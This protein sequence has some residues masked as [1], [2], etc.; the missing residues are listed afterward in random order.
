MKTRIF[1][2]AALICILTTATSVQ[3][4][5]QADVVLNV[6]CDEKDVKDQM[7]SFLGREL[8]SL[9]DVNIIDIPRPY[10][11]SFNV[12][13][14]TSEVGSRTVGYAISLVITERYSVD[15]GLKDTK[16]SPVVFEYDDLQKYILYVVPSAGLREGATRMVVYFDTNVLKREREI[17]QQLFP[18]K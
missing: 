3:K 2:A 5:Y 6:E 11:F 4:K 16:G 14:V 8:R 10:S 9:G 7:V 17:W 18:K 15:Q 13:V 1:V 12:I